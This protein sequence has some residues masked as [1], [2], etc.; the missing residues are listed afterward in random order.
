MQLL[1]RQKYNKVMTQLA[2][3]NGVETVTQQFNVTPSVQQKLK[4]K[5]QESSKFLSLINVYIVR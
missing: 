3:L 2:E 1:T 5:L 4:E